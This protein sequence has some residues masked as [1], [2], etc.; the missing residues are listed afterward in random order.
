MTFQFPE[1]RRVCEGVLAICLAAGL[2]LSSAQAKDSLTV[3]TGY[4]DGFVQTFE[5]AFEAKYPDVTVTIVHKS[6]HDAF[7][8]LSAPDHGGADV[9]WA[10]SGN[11]AH[12]AEKN[13]FAPL[14]VDRSVLPGKIG[15]TPISDPN[16]SFEAFELAGYG[17]AYGPNALWKGKAA[18]ETW[19]DAA[20]PVLP[21]K[22]IMPTPHVG[23]ASTLYE[24]LLQ[25]EGWNKGWALVSEIS[26]NATLTNGPPTLGALESGQAALILT[27]DFHALDAAAKGKAIAFAY[28]Q[29]TA[30]LPAYVAQLANAPH[31]QVAQAF[32][33]FLLSQEGQKL[34]PGV[35]RYPVRPDA[36]AADAVD[37]FKRT[38]LAAYDSKL[39]EARRNLDAALF[40]AAIAKPH[41]QLVALW[42]AI[43][44]AEKKLG[45]N[46]SGDA[47]S[48]LHEARQLA[49]FVPVSETQAHD[50][51]FLAQFGR[52]HEPP[53][54]MIAAWRSEIDAAHAKAA[55]ELARADPD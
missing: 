45:A 5:K 51:T 29:K 24:I 12:L 43:H 18:P 34:L 23:F 44:A 8:L 11:F 36:Y 9:Y 53:A 31:P 37:P 38:T 10:A 19:A 49:G 32:I 13:A 21:G 42:Q 20:K 30:F 25:G 50:T 46:P 28:P 6:G 40:D 3:V 14:K 35:G 55:A 16:G 48:I 1:Y 17:L 39:A 15:P 52:G 7:A 2:G 33:A 54:E 41:D 47:Q 4:P 27:I 22:I 26:S